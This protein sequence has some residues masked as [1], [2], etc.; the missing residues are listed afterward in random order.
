MQTRYFV[1]DNTPEW[2]CKYEIFNDV[3]SHERHILNEWMMIILEDELKK[4]SLSTI[5]EGISTF[6]LYEALKLWDSTYELAALPIE[7][8]TSFYHKL[9]ILIA[10][11]HFYSIEEYETD[12]DDSI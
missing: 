1:V 4:M 5:E 3:T 6:G 11:T 12:T 7:D 10:T 9:W 2:F 8:E